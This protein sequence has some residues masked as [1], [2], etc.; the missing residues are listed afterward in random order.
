MAN[1]DINVAVDDGSTLYLGGTFTYLGYYSGPGVITSAADGSVD[2]ATPLFTGSTVEAAIPDGVG[3]W[4]VGG[5][6][7]EVDGVA[8]AG[9]AHLLSSGSVDPDFVADLDVACGAQTFEL[10]GSTLYI[11]GLFSS[12]NGVPR[13]NVA[14]VDAASGSVLSWNPGTSNNVEDV[15]VP[16]GGSPIYLSGAF[17]TA[18]G[19]TRN[20]IAAV[21]ATTGLATAWNPNAG[22]TVASMA[23]TGTTLYVGGSFSSIGGA[24]RNRLA[25]LNTAVDTSNA[26]GWNPNA[27][28]SVRD[29]VLSGTTVYAGGYFTAI[30]AST[31]NRVAAISTVTGL[32]TAFNPDVNGIVEAMYLDGSTLYFGGNF[33]TVGGTPRFNV[34][35]VDVGTGVAT[36]FA[37]STDAIVIA[38]ASSG[39]DVL[40]GGVFSLSPAFR[41]VGV[42]A[43]DLASS[44][45]T[46]WDGSTNGFVYDLELDGTTLYAAGTFTSG[47]G[48]ARDNLVALD[49]TLDT[50]NATG[51]DPGADVSVSSI[52]LADSTLYV[53][54]DFGTLGG[55][56]RSYIGA[57]DTSTGAATDWAPEA[58]GPIYDML[59][60]GSTLYVGGD[61]G[62][63]GGA[64]RGGIAALDT[65]LDTNNATSWNPGTNGGVYGL[66][67]VGDVVYLGGSFST[68]GG[69]ARDNFAA[70]DATVDTNN[71]TSLVLDADDYV[72]RLE[73]YSDALYL[74]GGFTTLGGQPRSGV[75]EVNTDSSTLT[76]WA[77]PTAVSVGSPYGSGI[78]IVNGSVVLGGGFTRVNDQ[79]RHFL[80]LFEAPVVQF[81]SSTASAAEGAGATTL[82]LTL[83]FA[84]EEDVRVDVAVTGG[85]ATA[86]SDYTFGPVQTVTF[87]S[88]ATAASPTITVLNDSED[89]GSETVQLSLQGYSSG[90]G[91][92]TT[93]VLTLTITDQATAQVSAPN[94]ITRIEG[95]DPQTQALNVS[96]ARFDS[97]GS[98]AC[99]VLARKDNIV[100]ALVV[101]AFVTLRNCTLLLT[102]SSTLD[103]SVLA[104]LQRALGS[105]TET[106]YLTGGPVALTEQVAA[107]LATS[108]F[109]STSR[110]GGEHRRSTAK[111]VGDAIAQANQSPAT[112]AVVSE[113]S[114]LADALSV[115]AV[116]GRTGDHVAEP[117]L[118]NVRGSD[119]VDGTIRQFLQENPA[120]TTVELVGG[121][122][123]LSELF[124]QNLRAAF[125]SLIVE[126]TAGDDRFGTNVALVRKHYGT[127]PTTVAVARG[128]HGG[129]L[130][131]RSGATSTSG[132][133]AALLA[134][135]LAGGVES[136]LVLVTPTA[137][138]SVVVQYL[139]EAG[140]T[141]QQAYIVG[142][143]SEVSQV[144]EDQLKSYL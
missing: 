16:A 47:G 68:A 38:L 9:V 4:Y 122:A 114:Y 51:W 70:V 136:P 123:A 126:R 99:G 73:A 104:E 49:T 103:Q 24:L 100:D 31:R 118:L 75:A 109:Q 8:R 61:F 20:Y 132:A 110:I 64:G 65:T 72:W 50:N 134:G 52:A 91:S 22:G 3:G 130:G 7:T 36:S 133:Y 42:G 14:S 121:P 12:V 107:D 89:E 139:S 41:R 43:I 113:D 128:D 131:A 25:A 69:A 17:N 96:R 74:A 28:G 5:C 10:V 26:L 45:V 111:L 6:F 53:G 93:T 143:L 92:G 90:L 77:P 129:L 48:A 105:T 29:I 54:G 59:L 87:P 94:A 120:V 19:S 39:T 18:G 57:V 1:G 46:T 40:V 44:S 85:T 115:T 125:P 142:S 83:S 35:G 78:H 124:E 86:G 79:P 27:S 34:A 106:V 102:S 55:Q 117:T 62:T 60:D 2:A 112:R 76:D 88:G 108:G 82:P 23:L 66:E 119:E 135:T 58:D 116:T 33:S 37:A 30:G 101:G 21:D 137:I 140:A 63:I 71:A 56:T 32:A 144:V 67:K 127:T 141:L 97:P 11:G 80:A 84:A 95:A 138:P 98:A 15:L 13:A 81:S